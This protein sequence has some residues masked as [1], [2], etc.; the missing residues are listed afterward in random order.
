MLPEL[1]KILS[2]VGYFNCKLHLLNSISVNFQLLWTSSPKFKIILTK[3][4][5]IQNTLRSL[6][7]S[8]NQSINIRLI[9][10]GNINIFL[11]LVL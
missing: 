2:N 8:I 4:I 9:N 10:K 1:Y 3:V 11:D 7:E 6:Y 5:E